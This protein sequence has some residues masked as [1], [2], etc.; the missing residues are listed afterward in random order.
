MDN[1]KVSLQ[2]G[3]RVVATSRPHLGAVIAPAIVLV[4]GLVISFVEIS[5]TV[6]NF[7]PLG[8]LVAVVGLWATVNAIATW[9][10]TSLVMTDERLIGECGV[11]SRRKMDVPIRNLDS[12][13]AK[14]SVVGAL[15]GYGTLVVNARGH[16][17]LRVEFPQI[18]GAEQLA[19]QIRAM[20]AAP[21]KPAR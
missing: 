8:I 14:R 9:L 6:N 21:L 2:P 20:M 17:N 11:M 1:V 4:I 15:L 3:E 18:A 10:T 16:A 7:R 19:E 13:V 12:V 5:P